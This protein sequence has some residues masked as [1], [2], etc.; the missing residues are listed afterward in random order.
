MALKLGTIRLEV[1]D[2]WIQASI[3][4]NWEKNWTLHCSAVAI[5]LTPDFVE[6]FDG[7]KRTLLFFVIN[8]CEPILWKRT[9][10]AENI[11]QKATEPYT[12][13]H[14]VKLFNILN[15]T[16]PFIF[17]FKYSIMVNYGFRHLRLS[18]KIWI[19]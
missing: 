4:N 14:A 6:K 15:K 19:F 1:I 5:I 10:I 2:N 16:A 8:I 11:T 12:L 17:P 9:I 3:Q 18:R 7:R 13:S